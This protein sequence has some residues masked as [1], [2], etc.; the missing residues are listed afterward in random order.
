[1]A[2]TN[3]GTMDGAY[4]VGRNEILAWINTTLQLGLS[5]VEEVS[6]ASRPVPFRSRCWGGS[7]QGRGGK[8]RISSGSFSFQML[9]WFSFVSIR[10]G[11]D[12]LGV[13]WMNPW[14]GYF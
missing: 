9:G 13:P 11:V 12:S 7:L 14:V 5:K 2:A 1:M 4:F 3:I 10:A 6:D 8:R